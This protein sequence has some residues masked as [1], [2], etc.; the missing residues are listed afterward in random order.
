MASK[1]FIRMFVYTAINLCNH[2]SSVQIDVDHLSP[3]R[4]VFLPFV[5]RTAE[6]SFTYTW[7][8]I[9]C[10]F[11]NLHCD[12]VDMIPRRH[13]SAFLCVHTRDQNPVFETRNYDYIHDTSTKA[14][15]LWRHYKYT[16]T[17]SQF[18]NFRNR[19]N[20]HLFT[21]TDHK[22]SLELDK[23]KFLIMFFCPIE[24]CVF[25]IF[26]ALFTWN[27]GRFA[28]LCVCTLFS[29]LIEYFH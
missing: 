28:R 3:F 8:I 14:L 29:A 7:W 13:K 24:N 20:W 11:S 10:C 27:T 9:M 6:T 26:N 1:I 23:V 19:Y 18:S 21:K 4:P 22:E 2:S 16:T 25:A 15:H 5:D 12:D 17:K